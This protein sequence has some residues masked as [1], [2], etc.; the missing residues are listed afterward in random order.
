MEITT[1]HGAGAALETMPSCPDCGSTMVVRAQWHNNHVQGLTWTCRRAP[2]CEGV[3]RIRN[4]DEIRPINHDASTQAI[5]DWESTHEARAPRRDARRASE[6]RLGGFMGKLLSR[7][8]DRTSDYDVAT[9]SVRGSMG[10]FD[11]LVEL[12]FIVLEDR[13]LPHARAAMDNVLVGPSGV[14]V[15]ERKAWPGHLAVT[16]DAVYVDGRQRMG[17]TDAVLRATDAFEQTMAHELKPVAATVRPAIL[18]EKAA[19]KTVEGAVDKVLVGGTRGLPKLLRGTAKPV[20]GPETIVR[21]A[22]AADRLLE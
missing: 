11:S 12:G 9:H 2:G 7:P 6:S 1:T 19:N 17:A 13:H 22:L 15:V 4:P 10:Y 18:F 21:L 8:T 20:L 3:R 16:S 5:F 14:F